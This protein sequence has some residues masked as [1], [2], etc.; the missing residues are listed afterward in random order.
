MLEEPR[1]NTMAQRKNPDG[2]RRGRNIHTRRRG[3][4]RGPGPGLS[5]LLRKVRFYLTR[6]VNQLSME[7]NADAID[8]AAGVLHPAQ[9]YL[10]AFDLI[11]FEVISGSSHF[12]GPVLGKENV[13][14]AAKSQPAVAL[15][16]LTQSHAELS[17]QCLL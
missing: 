1:L 13:I 4:E 6:I 17:A 7:G 10:F 5:V 15:K 16:N 11:A 8:K 3:R 9:M 2:S 14:A 12:G